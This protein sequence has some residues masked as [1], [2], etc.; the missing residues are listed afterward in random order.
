MDFREQEYIRV[1]FSDGSVQIISGLYPMQ[2]TRKF[3]ELKGLSNVEVIE[4]W[5]SRDPHAIYSKYRL[6]LLLKAW[7]RARG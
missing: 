7:E 3:N 5:K 2:V 1:M 6:S 4:V